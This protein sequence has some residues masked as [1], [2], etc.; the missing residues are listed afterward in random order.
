M[1]TRLM[2]RGERG[3]TLI[4]LLV[5]IALA[6]LVTAGITYAIN[7]VLTINSRASNHMICVRQVQQAGKE[8]SKDALQAQEVTYT[9]NPFL[10]TLVWTDWEGAVNNVTYEIDGD[11]L[12]RRDNGS[13]DKVIAEYIDA[14]QTSCEPV[15]L[16]EDDGTLTFTVTAAVGTESETRI[17]EIEPRPG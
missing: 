12:V 5:A 2:H 4:E 8:V 3:F 10:L 1:N 13:G 11:K 17:Y 6:G 14:A 7:Q 9:A 16:L 15:G